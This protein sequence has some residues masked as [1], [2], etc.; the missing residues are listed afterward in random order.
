MVRMFSE[1]LNWQYSG[2]TDLL[3]FNGRYNAKS[4]EAM[5]DLSQV[6]ALTLERAIQEKAIQSVSALM[7]TVIA[8]TERHQG[9][10]PAWALSDSQGVRLAGSAL[11]KFLLSLLPEWV[12]DDT[13]KGLHFYVRDLDR[14]AN[15][16]K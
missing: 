9:N 8:V 7:E 2:E 10:N 12:R 5:L 14:R 16:A 1:T 6:V 3:I 11:K 4:G 13:S 15:R